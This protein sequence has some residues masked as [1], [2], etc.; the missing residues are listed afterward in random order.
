MDDCSLYIYNKHN[1]SLCS[2]GIPLLTAD[3]QL[4]TVYDY[5]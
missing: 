1:G 2:V 3:I 5:G 4:W